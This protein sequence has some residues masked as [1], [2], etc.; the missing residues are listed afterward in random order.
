LLKICK[1]VSIGGLITYD[2]SPEIRKLFSF[3][4]IVE[5]ELQYGMNNY[6]KTS[7]AKE[8]NYLSKT[9]N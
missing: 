6:K 2:D 5:W 9:I 7:A 4:D 3:A 1:N 8:K